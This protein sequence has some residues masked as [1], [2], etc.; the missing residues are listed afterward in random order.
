MDQTPF[1]ADFFTNLNHECEAL[2]AL[3]NL[4]EEER[5]ILIEGNTDHLLAVAERKSLAVQELSK[6]AN[7]RKNSLQA[8]GE[9]I[10]SLG[11]AIWLQ[12]HVPSSLP[13]WKTIL[14]WVAQMQNLNRINGLLINTKLR[15]NQQALTVL[16]KTANTTQSL[17]GAD[18]QTH[19]PSTRRIL[20]SV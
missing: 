7:L 1:A 20:G 14:D 9:E 13:V 19:I 18:G 6:L 3:V 11:I 4:L 10:K 5:Q 17:Y 2:G 8:Y 12:A 16:L 15:N